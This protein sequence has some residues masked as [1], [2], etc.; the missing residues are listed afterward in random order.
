MTCILPKGITDTTSWWHAMSAQADLRT[1][2]GNGSL[3]GE[4]EVQQR[5]TLESEE[6]LGFNHAWFG[7]S[8]RHG[9]LM[10]PQQRLVLKLAEQVLREGG[11]GQLAIPAVQRKASWPEEPPRLDAQRMGVFTSVSMPTWLSSGR[12]TTSAGTTSDVVEAMLLNDKDYTAMRVSHTFNLGG[13]AMNVQSACSSSLVALHTARCA[14]ER[15]DCDSALV[16]AASALFPH[17]QGYTAEPG[18]IMSRSGQCC[19]FDAA[20]DGTVPGSGGFAILLATH[21]LTCR[22]WPP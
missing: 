18:G 9:E 4:H 7:L 12:S 17:D 1:A 21:T 15:G 6:L 14:I 11:C 5:Y 2:H 8:K 10:D 20:A 13:P 3:L 16:I 22:R 19:P